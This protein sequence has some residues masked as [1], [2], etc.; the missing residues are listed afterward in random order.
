MAGNDA[1]APDNAEPKPDDET[2][3]ASD[4]NSEPVSQD[5]AIPAS[6]DDIDLSNM[7]ESVLKANIFELSVARRQSQ[8]NLEG[9]QRERAEFANFKKRMERERSDLFRQASLDTIANAL[10]VVD[11]FERAVSNVPEELRD[12]PWAKGV[13]LIRKKLET[14]MEQYDIETIDPLGDEFNPRLHEA[15]GTD[16]TEDYESGMVS[17]TLQK[18]YRSGERVLRPALVRVAS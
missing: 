9:W 10:S 13:M 12:D 2:T 8:V 16:D 11:D 3:H 5:G 15:V 17:A 14:W 18:G 7:D 1:E 4:E 6:P